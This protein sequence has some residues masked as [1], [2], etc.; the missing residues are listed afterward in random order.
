[1]TRKS[2]ESEATAVPLSSGARALM[3][4]RAR[5]SERFSGRIPKYPNTDSSPL[6]FSQ[7]M[8]WLSTQLDKSTV[9]Y[10]RCSAMRI[11]GRLDYAVLQRALSAIVERHEPLRSRIATDDGTP[12]LYSLAAGMI[13]LPVT[14][15]SALSAE[16]RESRVRELLDAEARRSFDLDTGPWLRA[17]ILDEGDETSTL[18]ITTH[19]IASDGWSD[20]VMFGELHALYG[21]FLAGEPSPLAELTTEYRDF[22]AWQREHAQASDGRRNAAYWRNRLA[23]A[24]VTQELP[25]DRPRPDMA[26]TAGGQ[27]TRVFRSELVESLEAIGRTEGTTLAMTSLAAFMLLQ[28]RITGQSDTLV[29]L[30]LAGRTH[31]E[32]EGLIGVFN[33]VVPLRVALDR[34]M[35]FRELLRVV[36][37]AVLEAHEHQFVPVEAILESLPSAQGVPHPEIAQTL[38]N[39]RN[40]PAFEPSLPGLLVHPLEMFNGSSVADLELEVV[41]RDEGWKCD[42]RFRTDLYEEATAARLLG[43]YLTLLESIAL[44]PDEAVGRLQ[45]LT[46]DERSR[47]LVDFNGPVCDLPQVLRIDELIREQ[48]GKTPLAVAVSSEESELT[49]DELDRQANAVAHDLRAR[50]VTN[51]DLIGICMER[52][53]ATVVSLLAVLKCGAA[54]VPFE[55]EHPRD[56]LAYMLADAQPVL[57]LAD[58]TGLSLLG[59]HDIEVL[60]VDS[61]YLKGLDGAD[62]PLLVDHDPA[63]VACV[64]YTSGSTGVPKGVLSTHRGIANNLLTMQQMYALTPDDCMLQHT[65]L[66]FDAAAWEIF[67]PLTVGARTYM[68]R[69]GGQRDAEYLADVIRDHHIATIG[70]A[71][72]MLKVMLDVPAFTRCAHLRRAIAIGEVLS[73]ALQK[74]FFARMP[75]VQMHNLYGPSETSITVTAWTCERGDTRRSVPIGRPMTNAEIYILDA[76][77]E[78]VPVGVAGEIY[79]GGVCVSNGYLNRPALTAERFPSHPF[80]AES[81][82]RVYRSGD[83]ARFGPDGVIEY[84]GRRDHQLKIRGVRVELGEIEAALDRLPAVRESVVVS[85]VDAEGEHTLVAYVVMDD[86]ASSPLDLRRALENRLPVQFLPGLIIPLEEIPHGPNGKVDRTALPDPSSCLPP[87]SRDLELPTTDLERRLAAI[88]KDLLGLPEVGTRD[89]FFNLGGHSLLAVRML[90][91]VTDQI[92]E[93]LSLRAFYSE[94]TLHGMVSLLSRETPA[95]TASSLP[96]ILNVREG[97]TWPP[98]FYLNGQPAGGGRYAPRLAPYLPADQ[99]FYVVPLPIFDAPTTVEGTAARMIEL[100]RMERPNGPYLLGGN[101]FGATLALEIA[102]QLRASGERVPLVAL[103]HPDALAPV[104]PG[105]RV[106]R[107]LALMTGIPENFHHAEFSS[108]LDYTLRTLSEIWR[109]QRGLSPR[110]RLDRLVEAGQ[111]VAGFVARNA[112]RP[113]TMLSTLRRRAPREADR[114]IQEDRVRQD[115]LPVPDANPAGN[116]SADREIAAHTRYME[117]AWI[118]YSLRPYSGKV[119]IIWPVEGPANP[120]WDPR[121]HWARLTPNFDWRDVPGNHWT[122]LHEHLEHSARAL[123]EFIEQGRGS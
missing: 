98:L 11:V 82:E 7:Q 104:H 26:S 3:E 63:D 33:C 13:P 97:G 67:W 39:F 53:V 36:R 16:T 65:S 58:R 77:R 102:R 106:M 4:Q 21:A 94:P 73:P 5:V 60:L 20:G 120:P 76:G 29:G 34:G 119:A 14:D 47:I 71:P 92:G 40:M 56:R 93:A 44:N 59:A 15:L 72:S 70:F 43:H 83:I 49:Y 78:P 46:S 64:L 101:C 96:P 32:V 10:N 48:A 55:T 122:M 22:A 112:R 118:D 61:P 41:E 24:P 84:I 50:G 45:L 2:L 100:I 54:F 28:S 99:G 89:S 114:Q 37:I 1:M 6:S 35:T 105:F 85:R 52:S 57:L 19:H 8:V 9:A 111:W 123:G 79:I 74:K 80:R 42:L 86:G 68:A 91:R 117:E 38:F 62:V 103:I 115:W 25:A 87:P 31:A 107:R 109:E 110:Q 30:S 81:G 69:P 75:H 88:W 95:A 113:L 17:G 23:G 18:Y 90:Q 121:A 12:R 66:G 116:Q 27:A 51:G 108:A